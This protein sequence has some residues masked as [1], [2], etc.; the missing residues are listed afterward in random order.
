EKR[1]ATFTLQTEVRC[2]SAS[3]LNAFTEELSQTVVKL[4]MKYHDEKAAKGRIF[5][6]IIGAYPAITK[7]I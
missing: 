3:D 1:F 2:A 7:K 6:F 4:V 5:K